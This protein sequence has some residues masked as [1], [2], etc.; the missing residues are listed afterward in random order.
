MTKNQVFLNF[1]QAHWQESVKKLEVVLTNGD[2]WHYYDLDYCDD[3]TKLLVGLL[4]SGKIALYEHL[5]PHK[6]DFDLEITKKAHIFRSLMKK[7]NLSQAL[8]DMAELFPQDYDVKESFNNAVYFPTLKAF[9]RCE[10]LKPV[11]L[12]QFF[13]AD[14][15]CDKVL[16]FP[17]WDPPEVSRYYTFERIISKEAFL[18]IMEAFS[19]KILERDSALKKPFDKVIPVVQDF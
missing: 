19:L 6:S 12:I 14:V 13:K 18:N 4:H 9:I 5:Y 1:D 8:L 15:C 16:V 7:R 3:H 11:Y 10:G 2:G 17:G